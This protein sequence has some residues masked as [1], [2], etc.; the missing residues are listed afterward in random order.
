MIECAVLDFSQLRKDMQTGIYPILRISHINM[1]DAHSA[2]ANEKSYFSFVL[3]LFFELW[4]IVFTIYGDTPSVPPTKKIVV[5]K[6]PNLQ[7][8]CALI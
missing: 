8:R 6:W 4:L 7:E 2:E 5:Q 3:F 1:K